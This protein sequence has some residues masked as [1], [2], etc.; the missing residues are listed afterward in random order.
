MRKKRPGNTTTNLLNSFYQQKNYALP[1]LDITCPKT[2][3]RQLLTSIA[4]LLSLTLA[5]AKTENPISTTNQPQPEQM[6]NPGTAFYI[7]LAIFSIPI[8]LII[9]CI[10]LCV[11]YQCTTR[12]ILNTNSPPTNYQSA[13]PANQ[14]ADLNS[15]ASSNSTI[16]SSDS[17]LSSTEYPISFAER[18]ALVEKNLQALAVAIPPIPNEY[19]CPIAEEIMT[20]PVVINDGH[21][22]EYTE[23]KKQQTEG[24]GKCPLDPSKKITEILP[25]FT[26]RNLISDFIETGEKL[27]QHYQN[28]NQKTNRHSPVFVMFDSD[29][30]SERESTKRMTV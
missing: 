28:L 2:T 22:Y 12:R 24:N 4:I 3:H 6:G 10:C 1:S 20:E 19:I 15:D 23:I 5:L 25:N 27:V 17:T 26:L 13:A 8:V 14:M 9:F 18:W 30:E 7:G 11:C 16:C 21:S 29:E